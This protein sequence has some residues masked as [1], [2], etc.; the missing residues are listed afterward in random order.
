ME[1][2]EKLRPHR[3]GLFVLAVIGLLGLNGIFVYFALL[4]P[5]VLTDAMKNPVSLVFMLE[6]FV[7]VGFGAWMIRLRGL[8]RPGWFA[9]VVLSLIGGLAFSVPA[10][11]LLQMRRTRTHPDTTI[12]EDHHERNEHEP[13]AAHDIAPG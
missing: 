11:L 1:S 5:T 7:M 6:A 3:T 8:R 2:F 12:R 13:I 9:F 10:V 4:E